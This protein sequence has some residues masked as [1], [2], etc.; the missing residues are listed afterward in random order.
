[1]L[2][3]T[4]LKRLSKIAQRSPQDLVRL[5]EKIAQS[6]D[7]IHKEFSTLNDNL[8]G[9]IQLSNPITSAALQTEDN[10]WQQVVTSRLLEFKHLWSTLYG[11]NHDKLLQPF[12]G[13]LKNRLNHIT[14]QL[15]VTT[16]LCPPATGEELKNSLLDIVAKLADLNSIHISPTDTRSVAE[17]NTSG[18]KILSIIEDVVTKTKK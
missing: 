1:M 8:S 10:S 4:A 13:K 15:L 2:D 14:D 18:D 17:F 9:G 6:V 3:L 12:L 7:Q 16:S 5:A 11:G